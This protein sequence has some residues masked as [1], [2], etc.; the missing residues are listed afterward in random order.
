MGYLYLYLCYRCSCLSAVCLSCGFTRLWCAKRLNSVADPGGPAPLFLANIRGVFGS[1]GCMRVCVCVNRNRGRYC[2]LF[3]NGAILNDIRGHSD[4]KNICRLQEIASN[5]SKFSGGSLPH[6]R[7][8]SR[9]RRSVRGFA[10][11]PGP[12]SK[13]PGSA[14]GT[15]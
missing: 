3:S 14:P 11:L 13:I 2:F 10:P 9:L 6:P 7:R 4:P 12:L 5:F 15:D 1:V 8:R